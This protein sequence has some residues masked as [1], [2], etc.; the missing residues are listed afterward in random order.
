MSRESVSIPLDTYIEASVTSVDVPRV[1]YRWRGTVEVKLSNRVTIYLMMSGSIAQ[2]LIPGEKVRLKL[3]SEPRNV[4]GDLIALPGEYELYRWWDN[5]WFPIW[6]PWRRETRLPRRDPITGRTIYEYT[7]IA[8]EAVTEQDYMEIV[9]LEQYH[10][11]SKEEIVAV[12]RCPICGR[13][14]ESNIQPSCPEHE[15][16][17]RLH[18]IRGSLPSSRFLVLELG[19][20]QP[21]EPKVVAYVRVDTPIPLMSRK[22]VEKERVVIERGIREKVFPKDW[23]HPT[24]WPLVYSRR[25]EILRRYRELSKM[26][27]SRKI[28]RTILGEEVSEEAIRNANT[29]AARIARVVVHPDYRG[30]GRGALAVK[31]AL[32]L[33][34]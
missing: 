21:F 25:M 11:A 28:A 34:K 23:F 14:I 27:R 12:W 33:S 10:Y 15:V 3:L 30:D 19:D 17:A 7:I 5:E 31:M 22:I 13:F 1:G 2:W 9:G 32:E 16:P 18:E 20:R 29:A 8:R 24:F 4:K 6:P 26:Y